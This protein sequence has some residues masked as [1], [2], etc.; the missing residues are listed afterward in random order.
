MYTLLLAATLLGDL[1]QALA[2]Q[3]RKVEASARLSGP[4][5]ATDGQFVVTMKDGREVGLVVYKQRWAFRKAPLFWINLDQEDAGQTVLLPRA[6]E[7]IQDKVPPDWL[8]SDYKQYRHSQRDVSFLALNPRR[9]LA[10]VN[11]RWV[12][13]SGFVPQRNMLARTTWWITPSA[14]VYALAVMVHRAADAAEAE[15]L[16]QAIEAKLNP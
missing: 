11:G 5:A 3:A 2:P 9:T 1:S 16:T 14:E 13:T 6:G 4:T 8:A 10:K 7:L 15:A 12:A